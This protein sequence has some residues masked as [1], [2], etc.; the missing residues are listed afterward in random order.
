MRK[1]EHHGVAVSR[2]IVQAHERIGHMRVGV[3]AAD[4]ALELGAFHCAAVRSLGDEREKR[5]DCR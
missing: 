3:V 1:V 4:F 5:D 2:I